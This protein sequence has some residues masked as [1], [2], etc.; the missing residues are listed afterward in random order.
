MRFRRLTP[1][2]WLRSG[3]EREE[4][5]RPSV[6]DLSE[7]G[8]LAALELACLADAHGIALR[9]QVRVQRVL[10]RGAVLMGLPPN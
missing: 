9:D 7:R 2:R 8:V 10:E 4:M 3:V 5:A 1:S 6:P